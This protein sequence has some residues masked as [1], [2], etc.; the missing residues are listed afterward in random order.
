M[1]VT[2]ALSTGVIGLNRTFDNVA[3]TAS[4]FA[5]V[6]KPENLEEASGVENGPVVA[7]TTV[8]SQDPS[9]AVS[10]VTQ[11]EEV[12]SGMIDVHV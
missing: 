3:K 11:A 9:N 8:G 6:G 7:D 1:N 4:D 12:Q 10:V 5:G 2:N